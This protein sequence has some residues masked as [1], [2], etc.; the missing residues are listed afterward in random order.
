MLP[1]NR[2]APTT[3]VNSF[4]VMLLSLQGP[5][6]AGPQPPVRSAVGVGTGAAKESAGQGRGP[7]RQGRVRSS[8]GSSTGLSLLDGSIARP[9][10]CNGKRVRVVLDTASDKDRSCRYFHT[11][12]LF[13]ARETATTF[14]KYGYGFK[15]DP[16][17]VAV[18]L[19]PTVPARIDYHW[20]YY[21]PSYHLSIIRL[22]A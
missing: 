2:T 13:Q 5:Q 18:H 11:H 21:C 16:T 1:G 19:Q 4:L 9:P 7:P 17:H 12:V 15:N 10:R 22:Q 6:L 14:Q 3:T 8:R 20:Y